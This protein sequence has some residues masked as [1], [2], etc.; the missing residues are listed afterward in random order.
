MDV[1]KLINHEL[2]QMKERGEEKRQRFR[3]RQGKRLF[4]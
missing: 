2:V 1:P 3:Q 4:G